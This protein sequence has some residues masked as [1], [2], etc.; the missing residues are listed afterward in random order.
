M[1]KH[2]DGPPIAHAA[3]AFYDWFN[4]VAADP[5]GIAAVQA[6]LGD[7]ISLEELERLGARLHGNQ[8]F[9]DSQR[10]LI[11]RWRRRMA[12]KTPLSDAEAQALMQELLESFDHALLYDHSIKT[13]RTHIHRGMIIDSDTRMQRNMP[14]WTLHLTTSGRGLYISDH[15]EHV[16]EPGNMLLLKPDAS[17]H[18]GLHPK[19][20]NW[21]HLW[22]LFQPLPHWG[23]LLRL[24]ALEDNILSLQIP[25]EQDC[26]H[27][28]ELFASLKALLRV[29]SPYQ[30]DLQHNR[31]E[32]ILLRARQY[33][34]P[35]TSRAIDPRIQAACDFMAARLTEKFSI[36]DVATHCHVSSSRLSH[37]FKEQMGVGPK[38]WISD[39][40]LQQA[41]KLLINSV[42]SIGAIGARLGYEDPSHFTKHFR[43]NMGCSPR[44]F[45]QSFAARQ[46]G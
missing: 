28:D 17:L 22:A 1:S 12:R 37:L 2:A 24:P 16:A 41:R 15:A 29:E 13:G 46:D 18:Y 21:E 23:Q 33:G 44:Q 7:I 43:S 9:L 27:L 36:E 40:R 14:C 31:L 8:L 20:D 34:D 45:R 4:G 30:S 26:A 39:Q 11:E 42:E 10:P 38:A 5:E 35:S 3:R 25:A 32:E 19:A 6:V